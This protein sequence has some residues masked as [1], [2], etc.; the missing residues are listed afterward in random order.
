MIY[1]ALAWLGVV[2]LWLLI[3]LQVSGERYILQCGIVTWL[4]YVSRDLSDK[5]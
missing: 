1:M 5:R 2:L 4:L 3:S